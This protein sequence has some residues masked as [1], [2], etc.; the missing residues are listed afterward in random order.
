MLFVAG[1]ADYI[2]GNPPAHHQT[3]FIY[4][5]AHLIHRPG[6]EDGLSYT[7]NVGEDVPLKDLVK[8]S[9]QSGSVNTD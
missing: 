9:V 4:R 8:E 3:G 5:L 6:E 1:C 2:F 7:F